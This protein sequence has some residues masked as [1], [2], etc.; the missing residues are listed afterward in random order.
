MYFLSTRTQSLGWAIEELCFK[1]QNKEILL[2]SKIQY[3]LLLGKKNIQLR[4]ESNG[5]SVR[6]V[7]CNQNDDCPQFLAH[8][9]LLTRE[10][11]NVC[12][13][14]SILTFEISYRFSQN[15]VII[16]CRTY[17][18]SFVQIPWRV[19]GRSNS[20]KKEGLFLCNLWKR[21]REW[22]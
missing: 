9:N 2:S 22:K 18:L 12:V 21:M 19:W 16:I 4:G 11:D 17:T 1:R 7:T 8:F 20:K 10:A 5:P 14:C 3:M 6:F 13:L 15:L